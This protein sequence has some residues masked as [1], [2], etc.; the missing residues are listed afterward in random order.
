MSDEWKQAFLVA[1]LML[2]S[3][4]SLGFLMGFSVAKGW[5]P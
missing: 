2:L 3:G 4:S 5:Y 1:A